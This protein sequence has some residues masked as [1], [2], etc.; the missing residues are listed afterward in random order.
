M[1]D[2]IIKTT[3]GAP[4]LD[5]SIKD[6]IPG[7]D[8]TETSN[9]DNVLAV[10]DIEAKHDHHKTKSTSWENDANYTGSALCGIRKPLEDTAGL[11]V[12][13]RYRLPQHYDVWQMRLERVNAAR[14]RK[15]SSEA[16]GSDN[17]VS[18]MHEASLQKGMH[19][20]I[21]CLSRLPRCSAENPR[22]AMAIGYCG[23]LLGTLWMVFKGDLLP[24][25]V[26]LDNVRKIDGTEACEF[27]L[28][29]WLKRHANSTLD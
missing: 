21:R 18:R 22:A 12:G 20:N 23:L 15:A 9:T 24:G 11:V 27:A 1:T 3:I 17:S 8:Y 6:G 19:R 5:T 16:T 7:I 13:P 29:I 4:R 14:S 2:D 10:Y 25:F 26:D 28:S